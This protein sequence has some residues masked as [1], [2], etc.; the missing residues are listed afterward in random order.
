MH[1][2]KGF[3]SCISVALLAQISHINFMPNVL[4]H[5]LGQQGRELGFLYKFWKTEFKKE[6]YAFYNSGKPKVL[7]RNGLFPV[8]FFFLMT[9]QLQ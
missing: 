6:L 7:E 2:L 5:E 3:S 8:S 4:L 9:S 1:K